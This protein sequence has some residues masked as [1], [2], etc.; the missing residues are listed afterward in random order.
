MAPT[1][2][3]DPSI[4]PKRIRNRTAES[5]RAEYQKRATGMPNGRPPKRTG[6]YEVLCNLK[7]VGC[8]H[9]HHE[10][11]EPFVLISR[12]DGTAYPILLSSLV[13]LTI[14][15]VNYLS[16]EGDAL[17]AREQKQKADNETRSATAAQIWGR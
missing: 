10:T 6:A 8:V 13:G 14:G 12:E 3:P 2:Y 16:L 9:Q 15:A 17:K 4:K 11:G 5:R 7:A 1:H